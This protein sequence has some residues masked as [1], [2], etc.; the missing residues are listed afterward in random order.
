MAVTITAS[1][2]ASALG[3]DAGTAT[4]L[5]EVATELVERYAPLAPGVV[6][7]EAVVRTSSWLHQAPAAGQISESVGDLSTRWSASSM[8]ALR[9]SSAMSLLS[10]WKRR[11]AGVL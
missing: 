2:L 6:Q 9:H 3:V 7:D 8:S 5:L 4:R 11:R 10:P 1:E